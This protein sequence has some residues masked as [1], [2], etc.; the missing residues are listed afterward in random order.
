MEEETSATLGASSLDHCVCVPA[1]RAKFISVSSRKSGKERVLFREWIFMV[2]AGNVFRI[3]ESA[4]LAVHCSENW[5]V[6]VLRRRD[7]RCA[8]YSVQPD[9]QEQVLRIRYKTDLPTNHITSRVS[10]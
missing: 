10:S 4:S 8:G 7:W 2:T 9:R 1:P 3:G 5:R 6:Q